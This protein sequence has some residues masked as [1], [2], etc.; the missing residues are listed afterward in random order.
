MPAS[1]AVERVLHGLVD[2]HCH[3]GPNPLPRRFDH[4]EAARDGARLGMRALLAKSHHHNT[5]MDLLAMKQQL[6]GLST[7]VFGGIALNQW[8]GGINPYAVELS[9]RMG[10]RAVW[11]P[12]VSSSAH[13]EHHRSGGGFPSPTIPLSGAQTDIRGEDGEFLPE[14][15]RVLDLIVEAGA[16]LSA[17]HLPSDD[18]LALFTVA[19]ERGVRR[20]VL[21]HPNFLIGSDAA[22]CREFTA[23]GAY[24]EHETSMYDPEVA[25]ARGGPDV[26]MRWI[27]EVG[28]E[29][30]VLASD[31]GQRGRPMPVDSF[32]RV[33]GALLDL[34]LPEKDLRMI[35]RDNPSFLL[36]LD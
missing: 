34:G 11:F 1:T 27:E 22:R 32:I 21:S 3:S 12:T 36:A 19:A 13:V 10:G 17:G 18:V 8:V 16:L 6:D 26:L 9:L 20:M 25:Q 33:G 30:T 2:L 31:L 5:V 4:V 23:L 24:I 29:H 15:Y 28:P 7:Q 35:V 14:V